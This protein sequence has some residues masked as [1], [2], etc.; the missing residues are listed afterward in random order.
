MIGDVVTRYDID[1]VHFDD[2]FYPYPA[3]SINDYKTF[4]EFGQ[5]DFNN[6]EDWRRHNVDEFI[7]LTSEKIRSI[8]PY[9]KFGVSPFGV[10]RNADRDPNGSATRAGIQTYDDLFADVLLLA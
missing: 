7:R 6:I 9:V 4:Q 3:Q 5:A 1:G 2:Y 10:W 8:K